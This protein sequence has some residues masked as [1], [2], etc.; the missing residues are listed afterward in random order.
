M[1]PPTAAPVE[2]EDALPNYDAVIFFN[3][4]S[5]WEDY[6]NIDGTPANGMYFDGLNEDGDAALFIIE[7]GNDPYLQMLPYDPL[8]RR[9]GRLCR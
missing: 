5:Y 8:T 3:E 2:G 1:A 7:K 6:I 9:N 4:E